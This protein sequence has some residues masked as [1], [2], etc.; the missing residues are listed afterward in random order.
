MRSYAVVR[1]GDAT[2]TPVD[3]ARVV[4][5]ADQISYKIVADSSTEA[6]EGT[7]NLALLITL[8]NYPI[9]SDNAHPT[10]LSTFTLT[11]NPAPCDC[12]Q[13][14]WDPPVP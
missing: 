1:A 10:L 13:L 8:V 6:H 12:S 4:T 2:Y 14:L 3:F 5:V 9:S 11:I 7:H